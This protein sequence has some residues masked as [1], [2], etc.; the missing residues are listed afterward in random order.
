VRADLALRG[1]QVETTPQQREAARKDLRH[2]RV[3]YCLSS[4][5]DPAALKKLPEAER[6][7]WEKLWADVEATLKK[8]AEAGKK[9]P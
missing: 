9:Q 4:L 7:D 5:R 3:D 8:A 2:W 1:K 6:G